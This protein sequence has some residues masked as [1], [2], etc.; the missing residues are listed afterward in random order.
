M[1][2]DDE[3][4]R[5]DYLRWMTNTRRL[6][7]DCLSIDRKGPDHLLASLRLNQPLQKGFTDIR[8]FR[9]RPRSIQRV[10]G[11]EEWIAGIVVRAALVDLER[12]RLGDGIGRGDPGAEVREGVFGEEGRDG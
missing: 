8:V 5:N 12:S 9:R 3:R 1:S 2:Y 11:V 7:D 4:N 6:R 10:C